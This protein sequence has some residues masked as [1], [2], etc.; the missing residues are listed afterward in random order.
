MYM[1]S[2]KFLKIYIYFRFIMNQIEVN[3]VAFF[4]GG[5][6]TFASIVT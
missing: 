5:G 1:F 6:V 2:V 3:Y 4:L